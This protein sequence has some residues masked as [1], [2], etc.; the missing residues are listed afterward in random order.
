MKVKTMVR[1][2][3]QF[4]TANDKLKTQTYLVPQEKILVEG[5]KYSISIFQQ[6]NF[7]SEME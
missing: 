3:L 6:G 7:L 4:S 1:D 2:T 5:V